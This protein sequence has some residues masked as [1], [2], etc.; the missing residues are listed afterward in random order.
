VSNNFPIPGS[1]QKGKASLPRK[2]KI[3]ATITML[4]DAVLISISR[5]NLSIFM[6]SPSSNFF[7]GDAFGQIHPH[8]CY[9]RIV[10]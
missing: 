6:S 4:I 2:R 9:R 3:M 10:T 1:N 5:M 7:A 8:A